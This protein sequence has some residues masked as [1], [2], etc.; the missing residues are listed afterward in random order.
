M[1]T[2]KERKPFFVAHALVWCPDTP[3]LVE[4]LFEGFPTLTSEAGKASESEAFERA[5][6]AICLSVE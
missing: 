4:V 5:A 6:E 1:T 2:R 3:L